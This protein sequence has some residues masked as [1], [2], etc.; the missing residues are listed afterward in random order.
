MAEADISFRAATIRGEIRRAN[1]RSIR[2]FR[3]ERCSDCGLGKELCLCAEL[4]VLQTRTRVH[5]FL[6]E[7]E[8]PKPTGTSRLLRRLVA[9]HHLSVFGGRESAKPALP[10]P[11]PKRPV[12]LLYP[13]LNAKP[14]E[15][16]ISEL[17]PNPLEHTP[18]LVVPDGTWTQ[19]RRFRKRCVQGA[20]QCVS[21]QGVASSYQ[22]R[23]GI[24]DHQLCT[25]EAVAHALGA[26]EGPLLQDQLLHWFA[27]WKYAALAAR[28]GVLENSGG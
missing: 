27:R 12:W 10:E 6:H 18:T 19:A 23:Q 15:R 8:V 16:V 28:R 1:S 25:F 24:D 21:I 14:L 2:G 26:L 5:L 11:Q 17:G 9:N 13:D 7:Q 3:L 22:L 4:P 20:L